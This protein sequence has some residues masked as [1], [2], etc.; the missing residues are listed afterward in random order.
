MMSLSTEFLRLSLFLFLPSQ[1]IVTSH[2]SNA[3]K[4]LLETLPFL[5]HFYL[6]TTQTIQ[7]IYT[8]LTLQEIWVKIA[9]TPAHSVVNAGKIV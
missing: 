3:N 5:D 2:V 7:M 9:D 4:S 1:Y 6:I 8:R